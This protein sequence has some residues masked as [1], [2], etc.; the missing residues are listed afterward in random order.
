MLFDR[1][2]K[3]SRKIIPVIPEYDV[4]DIIQYTP[5]HKNQKSM[6]HPVYTFANTDIFLQ[7]KVSADHKKDRNR[8]TTEAV[9]EKR[10]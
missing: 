9:G 2:L 1:F 6:D 10:K 4:P 5:E 3:K 7:Q 8:N